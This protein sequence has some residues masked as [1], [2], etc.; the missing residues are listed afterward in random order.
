M[1]PRFSGEVVLYIDTAHAR[2]LRKLCRSLPSFVSC[3]RDLI[4]LAMV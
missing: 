2:S 4:G 3:K 1:G